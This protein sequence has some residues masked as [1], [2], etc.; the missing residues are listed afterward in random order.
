MEER[1]APEHTGHPADDTPAAAPGALF[2]VYLAVF[3]GFCGQYIIAPILPPLA[4]E[5]DISEFQLGMVI[6]TSAIMVVLGSTF[7]GRRSQT[8]GRKRVLV[9][10]L[11]GGAAALL[12]FAVVAHLG[13]NH[14]V[15]G[16]VAFVM[17]LCTRGLVYGALLA[18]IPVTAQAYVADVT[19]DERSRV[20]GLS[21]VGAASGLAIVVGPLLG[22]L[23]G[24]ASLLLSMYVAP[25]VL[26]FVA[27]IVWLRLPTESRHVDKPK[28][29]K[30]SPFD[31]RLW[32]FLVPGFGLFLALG[33]MQITVGFL[34]QD[35]LDLAPGD[36]AQ[37]TSWAL[38]ALGVP[39]LLAQAALVPKLGWPPL[40][41]LR[42][43]I[44]LAGLG[45]LGVSLGAEL[46]ST[47]VSL[48][49]LGLGLGMGLPGYMSGPT[50][51]VGPD[52]QG[53]VAGI[54]GANNA[55]TFVFGPLI[56]TGLYQ[57]APLAP[58]ITT[59]LLLAALLLFVWLAPAIRPTAAHP[60]TR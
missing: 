46:I 6:T 16:A 14:T 58:F 31:R 13:L 9:L 57:L 45:F 23:L 43:G 35:R 49:V 7:W 60:N 52:E 30:L 39:Y 50:L 53:G 38:L 44:T 55:L 26:A 21:W 42:I 15:G 3:G 24:K 34:L 22:G 27:A 8:I 59:T 41:L 11:L 40:R 29:A 1:T 18:A 47:M 51:L 28:A 20:R 48:A 5:L 37:Y 10:T 36:A 25:A 12:L 32:P 33:I 19:P 4:R 17:M 54:V 2:L 56:G